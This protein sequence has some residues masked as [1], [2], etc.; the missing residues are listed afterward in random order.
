MELNGKAINFDDKL[1][2]FKQIIENKKKHELELEDSK[3]ILNCIIH[4]EYRGF[5]NDRCPTCENEERN[6]WQNKKREME[7]EHFKIDCGIPQ[8]FLDCG[9]SNY[10]AINAKQQAVLDSMINYTFDAN[11]VLSG[12]CGTGKTHLGIALI[13]R[14]I[15][16]YNSACCHYIKFY[17][18]A[19][20]AVT[21]H[22]LYD[23]ILRCRFLVIDEYGVNNTDYKNTT[24]FEVIDQRYDNNLYTM[25]ISNLNGKELKANMNDA[26]YSRIKESCI[27]HSF[28]WQDFR[29]KQT[30][31]K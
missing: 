17:Q 7:I 28:D 31:D 22:E 20:I 25:L 11:I 12:K 4:G 27:T 15:R 30:G 2:E 6:I 3:I 10:N 29:F 18:L 5:D 16:K 9:F 21:D 23:W 13:D 8:R 14:I 1:N 19:R 24:L 26:T